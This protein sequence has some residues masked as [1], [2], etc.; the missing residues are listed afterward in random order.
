M[1]R[2]GERSVSVR[3]TGHDKG[4]FTVT[5]GGMPN[6]RKLKSFVVFK[7]VRHIPELNEVTGV[8]VYPSRNGWMNEALTMK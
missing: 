2:V 1:A 7:D 3:T 6:S 5:L 8:V 4:R